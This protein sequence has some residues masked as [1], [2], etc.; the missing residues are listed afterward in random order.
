MEV[1]LWTLV[2]GMPSQAFLESDDCIRVPQGPK[3][4]GDAQ[5]LLHLRNLMK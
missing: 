1:G 2:T 3:K 5:R 4:L